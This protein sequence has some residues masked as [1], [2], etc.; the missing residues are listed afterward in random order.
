MSQN[1]KIDTSFDMSNQF[2]LNCLFSSPDSLAKRFF[3]KIG[4]KIE[5][6]KFTIQKK[7]HHLKI[8]LYHIVESGGVSLIVNLFFYVFKG[9]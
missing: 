8:R 7:I 4:K 6:K 3:H 1:C 2:T 9:K 5:T